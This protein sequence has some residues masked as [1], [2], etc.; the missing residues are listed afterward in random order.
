MRESSKS[1]ANNQLLRIFCDVENALKDRL[2]RP[3]DDRT[4]I[5]QLI[6]QF[7][8]KVPR[9]SESA[10]ALRRIAEI[11]NIL[12]HHGGLE[13]GFPFQVTH[14]CVD[15]LRAIH[16]DLRKPTQV[17]DSFR[18]PVTIVDGDEPLADVLTLAYAKGYSQFPVIKGGRFEGVITEN[19]I[20][21]WL[22]HQ[23]SKGKAEIDLRNVTVRQVLRERDPWAKGVRIFRF[24]RMDAPLEEVLGRFSNE[25]VLEVVLLTASGDST[26]PIEG[27]LTQW[28]AA[29]STNG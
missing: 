14:E 28:D 20:T 2:R 17:G 18:R 27:V 26:E 21:R 24:E 6:S 10:N 23:T 4:G 5:Q 9:W 22:G 15:E 3:T 13:K 7:E 19:E 25:P 29:R 11:R 16:T 8:K 1:D 12:T